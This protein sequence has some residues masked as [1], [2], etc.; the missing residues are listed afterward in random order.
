MSDFKIIFGG[1]PGAGKTTAIGAISD[2]PPTTTERRPTDELAARKT[3]TTVAMDYGLMRL[4]DVQ[5]LHL[6]G[7]PGQKRFEFMW[8]ILAINAIGLVLMIDG[9]RP[10]PIADLAEYLD[11]FESL[12]SRAGLVVGVTKVEAVGSAQRAAIQTHLDSRS[13][14][15]PVFT[16]DAR[17]ARDVVLLTQAL[18]FTLDPALKEQ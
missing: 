6:Y 18:L 12:V 11:G 9:S 3:A 1:P 13:L 4:D 15:A 17:R 2:I 5:T 8:E 14:C 10:D 7:T 16:V